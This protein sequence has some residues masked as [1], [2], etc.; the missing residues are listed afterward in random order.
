MNIVDEEGHPT[1]HFSG[2]VSYALW[3]FWQIILSNWDVFKRIW[4]PALPM[5]PL[6]VRIPYTTKTDFGTALYANS[7]TLTPGT[8]TVDIDPEKHEMIIHCLARGMGEDLNGG[9]MQARV[10]SYLERA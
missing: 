5:D 10:K 9:G 1:Q 8:V 4:N 3:L 7:I 2:A 6:F